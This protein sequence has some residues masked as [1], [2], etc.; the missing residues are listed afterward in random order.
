M[1]TQ[2]ATNGAV[3]LDAETAARVERAEILRQRREAQMGDQDRRLAAMRTA[4]PDDT[5]PFSLFK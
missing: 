4:L 2:Q 3:A 5:K 1:S